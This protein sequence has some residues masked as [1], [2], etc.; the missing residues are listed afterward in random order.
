MSR[1]SEIE[2][3]GGAGEFEAAVIA[4]VLDRIAT[5]SKAIFS[6][7]SPADNRLPEQVMGCS[8]RTERYRYTEWGEGK[9][10]VELYDHQTDPNEY[11][12]LA[13]QP[14]RRAQAVIERLRPLLRSKASGKTPQVPVN[15]ARL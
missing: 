13:R 1:M 15:P 5:E 11:N 4:V 9:H 2:I 14:D 3:K 12:N 10:G 8:V 6:R 7:P